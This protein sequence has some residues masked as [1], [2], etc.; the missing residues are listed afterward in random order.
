MNFLQHLICITSTLLFATAVPYDID[1]VT[2]SLHLTQATYCLDTAN[3]NTWTCPTCDEG[4]KVIS[5]VEEM[6]G[7]ALVGYN[8]DYNAIFVSYRG[9]EDFMNWVSL[10][11][12]HDDD[13]YSMELRSKFKI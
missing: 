13:T 4:M 7:R 2:S 9:S 11:R 10:F 12:V 3:Q 1:L 8:P 5:V 6:G